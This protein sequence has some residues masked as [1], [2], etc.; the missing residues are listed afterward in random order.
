MFGGQIPNLDFSVVSSGLLF[1]LI[2]FPD[3]ELLLVIRWSEVCAGINGLGAEEWAKRSTE[4]AN[5]SESCQFLRVQLNPFD[6]F[7]GSGR[8]KNPGHNFGE[9]LSD[10]NLRRRARTELFA[11]PASGHSRSRL[12]TSRSNCIAA[13]SSRTRLVCSSFAMSMTPLRKTVC[14]ITLSSNGSNSVAP[15]LWLSSIVPREPPTRLEAGPGRFNPRGR[16]YVDS[17]LHLFLCR[18]FTVP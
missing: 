5:I 12:V 4:P 15:L 2:R 3:M 6:G 13:S 1:Y 10:V 16:G 14:S 9:Y 7:H 18:C 8:V 11:L 17:W